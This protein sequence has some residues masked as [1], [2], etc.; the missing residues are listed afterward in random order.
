MRRW[1]RFEKDMLVGEKDVDHWSSYVG[2]G[3]LRFVLSF[4]VQPANIAFGQTVILAKSIAARDR[5]R[6][7]YQ[8]W[9]RK[10]FPGNG[11][12]GA[13]AR[14]RAAGGAARAIPGQRPGRPEGARHRAKA[15]AISSRHNPHL[16]DVTFDWGE[17]ARV[18]Q[19]N[20]LQDKARLL[21]VSSQDIAS[22]I[23]SVVNGA[24]VTQVRDDI[25]LVNVIAPRPRPGAR[26]GRNL[27]EPAIAWRQRAVRAAR[28]RG[29]L[30]LRP[31]AADD[32]AALAP[33]DHHPEGQ[34]HRYDVQ[35]ATV[36]TQLAPEVEEI[37]RG[38]AGRLSRRGRRRG[39]GKRQ[40]ARP[41]RRRGCR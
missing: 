25:Y 33:A 37:Q 14:H 23:N 17:P 30:R 13:S 11:R 36:V 15:R 1:R 39:R 3:A 7:K 22:A 10:A 20:V 35:P 8:D 19:V 41:D 6:G 16:A 34:H 26:L 18:V 21:G 2:Q 5:L 38:P 29:A 9:L 31:G 32:L 27:A 40:G 24:P 12:A 4:D 28:S